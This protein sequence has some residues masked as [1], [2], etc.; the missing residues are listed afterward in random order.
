MLIFLPKLT[1]TLQLAGIVGLITFFFLLS[2][3]EISFPSKASLG[4][5]SGKTRS[6]SQS[7]DWSSTAGPCRA[8]LAGWKE[9]EVQHK[10]LNGERVTYWHALSRTYLG[11]GKQYSEWSSRLI[12]SM[13][14]T[15]TCPVHRRYGG[16]PD[17]GKTMCDP[18]CT[19]TRPSCLVYSFGVG[20]KC[21]FESQLWREHLKCEVHLFDPTPSVKERFYF[22]NI[23]QLP[24]DDA[25]MH[26]HSLGFGGYRTSA[27]IEKQKVELS[28][29]SEIMRRLGHEGRV[30]DV[31]KLDVEGS[32]YDAFKYL[33]DKSEMPAAHMLLL[34][35]HIT[36][37][38]SAFL[39][40]QALMTSLE[41]ANFRLYHVE[42]NPFWS[43][44]FVELAF[45]N[46]S[47]LPL[48]YHN[49]D[50]DFDNSKK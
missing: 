47:M 31:L 34:E 32:E 14:P 17:G 4:R 40:F 39:S 42:R 24:A 22:G 21:Q 50:V 43:S 6:T 16:I 10:Q 37:D 35:A 5:N 2:A 18:K 15:Y 46:K 7:I 45:L 20:E 29:L 26:F 9:A 30:L 36:T 23:C 33:F 19:L 11:N 44:Y 49:I 25:R 3:V 8:S 1:T 27:F 13:L 12:H 38:T 28:P 41:K 48:V